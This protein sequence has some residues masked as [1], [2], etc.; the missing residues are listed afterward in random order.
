MLWG[1]NHT[2]PALL[3][4]FPRALGHSRRSIDNCRFNLAK[5]WPAKRYKH[6]LVC[7][8]QNRTGNP[9]S[10]RTVF[11]IERNPIRFY[12]AFATSFPMLLVACSDGRAR[13]REKEEVFVGILRVFL[14][15]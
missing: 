15:S 6:R 3:G 11:I 14:D 13:L 9:L 1:I 12:S 2:Q 5:L 10:T 4:A 8:R 7:S